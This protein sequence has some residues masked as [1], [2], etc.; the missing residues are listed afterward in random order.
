MLGDKLATEVAVVLGSPREAATLVFD[1]GTDATCYQMDLYQADRL[2]AA[3]AEQ[4]STARVE[5]RPDLWDLPAT[6]ATVLYL[7]ARGSERALKYD[8]IEQ[9]YHVLKPGGTFAALSPYEHDPLLP[10]I[11]KKVLGKPHAHPLGEGTLLWAVRGDD[12][13]R[14]RHEVT[15]HGRLDE[16][17][18]LRFVSR[19]GVFSYGHFDNGSRALIETMEIQ[20][21]DRVLDLGCGVGTNGIF[22]ARRGAG[23]VVFVDSNARALALAE[24]NARANGVSDFQT[25]A[26]STVVGVPGKFDVILANPPYYA[27]LSIAE[28]FIGR[29][30]E[31]LKPGGRFYVVSKQLLDP[32]LE[33]HFAEF[34]DETRRGYKIYRATA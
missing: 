29:A 16:T 33:Q 7:V 18:S 25:V 27:G 12:R 15:F 1:A 28:L 6:F 19:P 21:G 32:L 2:N 3:L 24:L 20:P 17:T 9:A 22:A 5:V 26:T 34:E 30:R 13:P 8:M 14:R 10:A 11:V 31:L 4:G 23:E